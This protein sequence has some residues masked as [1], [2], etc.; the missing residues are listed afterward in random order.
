MCRPS[1]FTVSVDAGIEPRTVANL[2]LTARRSSARSPPRNDFKTWKIVFSERHIEHNFII[3]QKLGHS[4]CYNHRMVYVHVVVGAYRAV[5]D[6][7]RACS[8]CKLTWLY[9][10]CLGEHNEVVHFEPYVEPGAAPRH[11]ALPKYNHLHIE[12]FFFPTSSQLIH[13]LNCFSFFPTGSQVI[14]ILNCFFFLQVHS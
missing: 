10:W 4:R 11:A 9:W 5:H 3:C 14:H 1:D 2:T 12:L 7:M 13:K 6:S 8:R